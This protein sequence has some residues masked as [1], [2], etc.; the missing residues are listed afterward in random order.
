MAY[1]Q[2]ELDLEPQDKTIIVRFE[3]NRIGQTST[4]C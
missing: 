4:Y 3:P 1:S 2:A